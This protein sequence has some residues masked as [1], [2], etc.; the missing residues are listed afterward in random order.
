MIYRG[1]DRDK[2]FLVDDCPQVADLKID[3][4]T[5]LAVP[6]DLLTIKGMAIS[7]SGPSRITSTTPRRCERGSLKGA[8]DEMSLREAAKLTNFKEF[9]L[10]KI[11]NEADFQ[12]TSYIWS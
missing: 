1:V 2:N 4:K 7:R 5:C 9:P 3:K 6:L 12:S 11:R 8:E 10:K